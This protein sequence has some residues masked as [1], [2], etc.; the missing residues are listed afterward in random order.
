M[1]RILPHIT[2]IALLFIV[3][4]LT[5]CNKQNIPDDIN[6]FHKNFQCSD[7]YIE[8]LAYLADSCTPRY[9]KN[10]A[11]FEKKSE[12]F[13]Q[14]GTNNIRNGGYLAA[15]DAF[16]KALEAEKSSIR[17][18][19]DA[20]NDDLHY[21]GQ[22]F[23]SIGDIYNKVNSVKQA[24]YFY[25]QALTEFENASRQHEVIEML[26]K[27]GDLYQNNH[28]PNIALLNYETAEGR[29]NLTETLLN[30]ILVRKG[31][32]LYDISDTETADSIYGILSQKTLQNIEF[33][34]FTACYFYHHNDFGDALPHL[35]Y[36]FDN[37]N[38]SM[39]LNAAEK[40]ADVNF[41]LGNRDDELT[42]AQ[43]QAKATS[44]EARLT[45]VKM[46]LETIGEKYIAD[47]K[48]GNAK[49]SSRLNKTQI[50]LTTA[51]VLLLIGAAVA[52]KILKKKN[53]ESS[54]AI[55]DIKKII[56]DKD[57]IISDK[58]KIINDISKKLEVSGSDGKSKET[59]TPRSFDDDL[60]NFEETDIYKEL[61]GSF[62]D[63]T[64]MTKTVGDY[65]QLALS[66]TKIFTLTTKFNE[67]FPNLTRTLTEIHP[68][69]TSNDIRYIMLGTMGFSVLEIAVLLQLTYSSTV[70]RNKH[71]KSVLDTEE[72]LEHFL[73]GYLRTVR[74]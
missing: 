34:Y 8:N 20:T 23:E 5:R 60:R 72:A 69:L 74:Y 53:E 1:N 14:K 27:I 4:C 48:Q 58:D 50:I 2:R 11:F 56:N 66:K 40:L 26:L 18:K 59:D 7:D 10:Y 37:G 64:V 47:I 3:L 70:K 41:R 15:A 67:C 36:C 9:S 46:E 68:D 33:K 44:A 17:L 62:D 21:L 12:I 45:P 63:I 55:D 31:I 19:G 38:Q 16:F 43:F 42:Y 73:P 57:K 13:Y 52:Y 6:N 71:I 61:K 29:K 54:Q 35:R 39:R 28:I 65:P 30:N 22:V 51:V 25:E 49:E 32:A 24:S